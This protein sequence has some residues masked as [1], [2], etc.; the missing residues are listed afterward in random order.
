MYNPLLKNSETEENMCIIDKNQESEE[1]R[2]QTLINY[3][4]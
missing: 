4:K 3:K 2:L 1:N